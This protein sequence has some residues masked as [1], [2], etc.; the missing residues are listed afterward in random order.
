[1]IPSVRFELRNPNLPE[2]HGDHL[3]LQ[4]HHVLGHNPKTP[5]VEISVITQTCH[6]HRFDT[7]CPQ[8]WRVLNGGFPVKTLK[9]RHSAF[10]READGL[11]N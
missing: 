10:L 7:T 1:V 8:R 3:S 5:V 6:A 9:I 2:N 4:L 11:L